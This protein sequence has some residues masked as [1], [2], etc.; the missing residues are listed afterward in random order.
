[1]VS[2]EDVK[3]SVNGVYKTMTARERM[4]RARDA[5]NKYWSAARRDSAKMRKAKASGRANALHRWGTKRWTA[6]EDKIVLHS[7]ESDKQIERKIKRST[8]AIAKRRWVL[9]HSRATL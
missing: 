9:K 7:H 3:T 4:K 8:R 5:S 2:Q 6:E 1:V